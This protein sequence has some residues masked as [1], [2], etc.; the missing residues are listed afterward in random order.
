MLSVAHDVRTKI[1]YELTG[2]V[3]SPYTTE[4][5]RVVGTD[6]S[7]EPPFYPCLFINSL[8]EPSAG[9]TLEKTQAYIESTIELQSFSAQT[10]VNSQNISRSIVDLAGDVL[11]SMGYELIAGP[12]DQNNDYFRT[13]ARF[14]RIVGDGDILY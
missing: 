11:I 4:T 13:I 2:K 5:L 6:I 10:E 9:T 3:D 14:R 1:A 7:A 8:G 12:Y